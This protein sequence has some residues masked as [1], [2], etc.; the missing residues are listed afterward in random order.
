[1]WILTIFYYKLKQILPNNI[2]NVKYKYLIVIKVISIPTCSLL[3]YLDNIVVFIKISYLL[4]NS[5][6]IY[7]VI[8]FNWY[9]KK[10]SKG[11][12][13]QTLVTMSIALVQAILIILL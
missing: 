11:E 7:N 12:E 5:Q 8:L 9:K 10:S 2:L 4:N 3:K 6:V 13:K 1:M